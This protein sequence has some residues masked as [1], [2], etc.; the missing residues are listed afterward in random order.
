MGVSIASQKNAIRKN[1][2]KT[3]VKPETPLRTK[4]KEDFFPL[5]KIGAAIWV[6]ES[7]R[8]ILIF[9]LPKKG[10]VFTL[11]PPLTFYFVAFH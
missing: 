5:F 9:R 4:Y 3:K 6:G 2:R 1:D 8:G 10:G 7:F 11:R